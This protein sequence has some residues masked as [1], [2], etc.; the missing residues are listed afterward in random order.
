MP[1]HSLHSVVNMTKARPPEGSTRFTGSDYDPYGP[2]P[3]EVRP[4]SFEELA[5]TATLIAAYGS[6]PTDVA[7]AAWNPALDGIAEAYRSSEQSYYE[8]SDRPRAEVF[9]SSI[10]RQQAARE[11]L[12][13]LVRATLV[14]PPPAA[15][16]ALP[17]AAGV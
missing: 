2:L 12:G 4:T 7:Y 10:A 16:P 13:Q 17:H 3:R 11:E 14:T 5:E 15:A 8:E 1:W 9:A 6:E